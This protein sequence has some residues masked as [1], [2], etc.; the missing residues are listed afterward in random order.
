MA[1][2][3]QTTDSVIM[4][5]PM[6]FTSNPETA[7]SNSFQAEIG[8]ED[9]EKIRLLAQEEFDGLRAALE[10]AGVEVLA[11]DDR[12]EPVTPDALFPNN[13]LS[14]HAD[15]SVILYPMEAPSRRAERRQ[16]VVERLHSQYGYRVDSVQDFSQHEDSGRYLEGTGSLVL[17]RVNRIAYACV[18]SRTHPALLQDWCER[19]D[20]QSEAFAAESNGK[21]IY[22]SN[23]MMCV[24]SGVA[25]ICDE[26]I[27]DEQERARVLSRLETT[28][29]EVVR[30]SLQQMNTF[31]G[32]M[33]E[34]KSASGQALLA[35]SQQA[36]DVLTREQVT[37]LER[38]V[39]LVSSDIRTIE[40]YAGGSVRCMLAEN[41]LPKA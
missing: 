13:W 28:G 26:A 22:H 29:H 6:S 31:A 21:E 16:D 7:A 1:I 36:R 35:M 41:F 24:G 37:T 4:I 2:D 15:G 38:H 14:T 39:D 32:N 19:F 18:S 34:L 3:T 25:V 20:Y 30:I 5:R 11:F 8:G 12:A 17:D 33:L 27:P 9:P 40:T 23:V 10:A